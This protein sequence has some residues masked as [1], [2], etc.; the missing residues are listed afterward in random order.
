MITL[1]TNLASNALASVSDIVADPGTLLIIVAVIGL[2][3]VFWIIAHIRDLFPKTIGKGY[4][5][6]DR[7]FEVKRRSGGRKYRQYLDGKI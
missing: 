2:P 5:A 7:P 4:D 1:P 6:M 3:L